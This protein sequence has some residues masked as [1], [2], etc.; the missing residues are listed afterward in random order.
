MFLFFI[1]CISLFF[2]H[3]VVSFHSLISSAHSCKDNDLL[4]KQ[5][6]K[7]VG[8]LTATRKVSYDCQSSGYT[9]LLC[10]FFKGNPKE[11]SGQTECPCLQFPLH[12]FTAY[13]DKQYRLPKDPPF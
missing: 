8:F 10:L 11:L 13:R 5:M 7:I 6:K 3:F 1:N 4:L 2:N 12:S 9:I